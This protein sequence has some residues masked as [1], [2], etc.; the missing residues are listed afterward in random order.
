MDDGG[1]R[2]R[3]RQAWYGLKAP[4][5]RA[6]SW[7]APH[8]LLRQVVRVVPRLRAGGRLPAPRR[9][10]EVRGTVGGA[11]FVMLNPARCEIAKE[12]YWGSGRRPRP[13][14]ALALEVF[15]ALARDAAVV[16]DIGA[17]TGVFTLAATAVA[18]TAE[19]HAF[20]IVPE[21]FKALV[22]NCARNDVL[23]RAVLH[24]AGIG[25]EGE[26]MRVA[27]GTGGSALPSCYS[28]RMRFEEGP[29]VRFRSLDALLHELPQGPTLLK[30]DVEG[31][32]EAVFRH[33]QRFLAER[34]P[35]ILC[36]V[37]AGVADG[38]ALADLLAPHGYRWY[39][40]EERALR[41]TPI[42]QPSPRFRDWLFTTAPA[43]S[44]S[45]RGIPVVASDAVG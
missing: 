38:R 44:L 31:T 30:V 2:R 1:L 23:Y 11:T 10:R 43:G 8:F 9:L 42:L 12:L 37:L 14:D 20:E 7:R 4:I 16:L 34:R 19:V 22:D 39:L 29:L 18:P 17:Y 35:D 21:V 13:E 24:L 25:A 40:V 6:L 26:T 15:A 45:A 33:G 36:E 3:R 32:E 27:L 41:P 5:K 28:S